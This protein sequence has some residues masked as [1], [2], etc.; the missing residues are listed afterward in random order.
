MAHA[1]LVIIDLQLSKTSLLSRNNTWRSERFIFVLKNFNSNQRQLLFF[2][3]QSRERE[4]GDVELG[5]FWGPPLSETLLF[6]SSGAADVDRTVRR[7]HTKIRPLPASSDS[8]TQLAGAH[9]RTV[10]TTNCAGGGG[11]DQYESIAWPGQ[12]VQHPGN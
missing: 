8:G 3:L 6:R 5:P 4:R 9:V 2:C 7:K 12:M 1:G 10:E 11:I